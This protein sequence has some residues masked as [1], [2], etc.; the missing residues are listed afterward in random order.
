M[1]FF[2]RRES[3][4]QGPRAPLSELA[5]LPLE[6]ALGDLDRRILT[7]TGDA[8]FMMNAQV[9]ETA[10]WHKLAI[11]VVI[12]SDSEYGLIRWHQERRFS[13]SGDISFTNPDFAE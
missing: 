4:E 6:N 12:W 1:T 8:G 9:I 2:A 11:V 5:R 3:P 13:R 10:L 7:V